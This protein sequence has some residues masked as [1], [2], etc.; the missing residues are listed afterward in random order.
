MTHKVGH[1]S[2]IAAV[3]SQRDFASLGPAGSCPDYL[4]NS[5]IPEMQAQAHFTIPVLKFGGGLSYKILTPRLSSEMANG[6]Y[7]V[8]ETTASLS[9]M[10]FMKITLKPIIIKFQGRYGEN[11]TDVL[12]IGGYAVKEVVNNETGQRS[13]T[14]FYN[15]AF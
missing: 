7:K 15:T 1:A 8:D 4:R 3:M 11:N 12:G 10:G 6:T 13:Y 14:P 9:A 5:G 2:L